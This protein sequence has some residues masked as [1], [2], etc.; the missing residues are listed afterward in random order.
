[1]DI[2]KIVFLGI[3]TT[4]LYA[5]LRQLKPETAPLVVLAGAAVIIIA[6]TDGLLGISEEIDG[7]MELAGLEKEN[8][9]ILM[10]SL[11]ICVVTQF[12]ADICYDN[13]C[14][15]IAAAVELAGRVGAIALAMPMIKTVAQLAIGLING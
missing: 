6:L 11:G 2:L 10:K 8:V 4:L 7:M 12:A 15:S 1:M 13:S 14:S 5:L 3:L 9:S